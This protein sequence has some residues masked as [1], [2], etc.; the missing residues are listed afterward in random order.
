MVPVKDTRNKFIDARLGTGHCWVG[1]EGVV[2]GVQD[3]K[4]I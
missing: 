2:I 1:E 3:L 4:S